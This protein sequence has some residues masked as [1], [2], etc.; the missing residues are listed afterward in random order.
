MIGDSQAVS[1]LRTALKD[2]NKSVYEQ[3][4]KALKI[5]VIRMIFYAFQQVGR[6]GN[7]AQLQ[8]SMIYLSTLK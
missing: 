5:S 4:M 6:T 8:I 7:L 1:A 2:K 3:I